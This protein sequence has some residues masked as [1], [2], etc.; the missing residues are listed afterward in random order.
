MSVTVELAAVRACAL[1]AWQEMTLAQRAALRRAGPVCGCSL[2]AKAN[3]RTIAALHRHGLVMV[4]ASA[5]PLTA[6]GRLVREVGIEADEAASRL[7][8]SKRKASEVDPMND[9]HAA[10]VDRA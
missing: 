6:L 7:R 2:A 3:G 1:R 5:S 10:T 4:E 8:Y 9:A